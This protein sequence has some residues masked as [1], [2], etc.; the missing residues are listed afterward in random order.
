MTQPGQ[1][2]QEVELVGPGPA[3]DEQE[4]SGPGVVTPQGR[5]ESNGVEE[6]GNE[7]PNPPGISDLDDGLKRMVEMVESG[8]EVLDE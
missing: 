2:R 4:E 5:I 3:G 7:E 6:E 8:K 1:E